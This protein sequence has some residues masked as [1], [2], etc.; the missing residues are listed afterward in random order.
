[1]VAVLLATGFEE[2][3]AIVP[4]DILKRGGVDVRLVSMTGEKTVVGSHGIAVGCDCTV[5]EFVLDES[6]EMLMLPGGMPGVTNLDIHPALPKLLNDFFE[7]DLWI[8][9]ICAAPSLLGK[10]GFLQGK[11]AVCYPGFEEHLRGAVYTDQR[12]VRDGRIITAKGA[13]AASEFGFALLT[14]L[15]DAALAEKIKASMY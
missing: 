8:T 11:H 9:A 4:V 6:A 7:R 15:K 14:V 10:R 3:E 5:S 1:M 2:S 13:G 12:V